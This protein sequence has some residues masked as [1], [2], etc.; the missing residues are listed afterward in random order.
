MDN[1]VTLKIPRGIADQIDRI[2][3][4][5]NLGYRSRAEFVNE[6]IRVLLSSI[7]NNYQPNKQHREKK[8]G[9]SE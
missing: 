8:N 4:Q 7:N 9:G 2:I 1:Y 5:G 6:G 3:E